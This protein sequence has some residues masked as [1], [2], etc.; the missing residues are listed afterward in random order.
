MMASGQRLTFTV[1]PMNCTVRWGATQ[2]AAPRR[3]SCAAATE[4]AAPPPLPCTAAAAPRMMRTRL[5]RRDQIQRSAPCRGAPACE[6]ARAITLPTRGTPLPPSVAIGR[7]PPPLWPRGS[8]PRRR[9]A[10]E[11]QVWWGRSLCRCPIRCSCLCFIALM[12]GSRGRPS[13]QHTLRASVKLRGRPRSP[14]TMACHRMRG[15]DR[16][17]PMA[18]GG[19]GGVVVP[20]F[21]GVGSCGRLSPARWSVRLAGPRGHWR[22]GVIGRGRRRA[23]TVVVGST[24]RW[25]PVTRGGRGVS[26]GGGGGC[27]GACVGRPRAGSAADPRWYSTCG[28]QRQ[29]E[30][31]K[32]PHRA[33]RVADLRAAR[34]GFW[35]RMGP[36]T[37]L[38][39]AGF[40]LARLPPPVSA[41]PID[42]PPKL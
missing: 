31:G 3:P 26:G 5:A 38:A 27:R 12:V 41:F 39:T 20:Q 23:G 24:G 16:S 14:S 9:N 6:A 32:A 11:R 34:F 42:R 21:D 22:G 17:R 15:R 33:L 28:G 4:H 10:R 19:A 7:A 25:L 1:S 30:W 18:Q 35:Y 13:P 37:T 36:A 2:L 29:R 8:L 40:P